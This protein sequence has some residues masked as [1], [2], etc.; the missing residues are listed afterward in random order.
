MKQKVASLKGNMGHKGL[1]RNKK[2][3]VAQ[4]KKHVS[5]LLIPVLTLHADQLD[6]TILTVEKVHFHC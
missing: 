2:L 1:A 4:E 5:A 6:T 3:R